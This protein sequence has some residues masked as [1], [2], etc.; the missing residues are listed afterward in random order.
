MIYPMFEE[1]IMM[2]LEVI[3]SNYKTNQET[4]QELREQDDIKEFVV[5]DTLGNVTFHSCEFCAGPVLGHMAH[6]C[7]QFR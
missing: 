3:I 2:T 5:F 4:E 6:K 1:E 7:R